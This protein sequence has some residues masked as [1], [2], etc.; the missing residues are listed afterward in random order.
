MRMRRPIERERGG[1]DR[2]AAA[3]RARARRLLES[4]RE[5]G[6]GG[7]LG[8]LAANKR[9]CQFLEWTNE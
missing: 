9:V 6:G 5:G 3:A 2:A 4:E 7:D 1:E 8:P